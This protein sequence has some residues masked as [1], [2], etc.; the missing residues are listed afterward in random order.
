MHIALYLS[1]QIMILKGMTQ[2]T[3]WVYV[4]KICLIF[5]QIIYQ[6]VPYA[7]N[8]LPIVSSCF[9]GLLKKS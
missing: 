5:P 4:I 9:Q 3:F 7:S 8:F 2:G 6:I 1:M